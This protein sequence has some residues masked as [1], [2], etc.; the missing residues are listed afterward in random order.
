M[1]HI[2]RIKRL[3]VGAPQHVGIDGGVAEQEILSRKRHAGLKVKAKR[4]FRKP[5]IDLPQITACMTKFSVER[6]AECPTGE[7]R[8]YSLDGLANETLA[9]GVG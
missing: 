8:R 3:W 5:H 9:A 1:A 7:A 6:S 2:L 4:A